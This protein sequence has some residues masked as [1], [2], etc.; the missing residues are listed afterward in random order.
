ML[1]REGREDLLGGPTVQKEAGDGVQFFVS[2]DFAQGTSV[3]HISA[4]LIEI[5]M[6]NLCVLPTPG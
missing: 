4:P 1:G 6:E 3:S 5:Q 2:A